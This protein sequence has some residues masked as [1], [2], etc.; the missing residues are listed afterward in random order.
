ALTNVW[1]GLLG[2]GALAGVCDTLAAPLAD[3][4]ATLGPLQ[5]LLLG[6]F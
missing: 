1:Y 4:P 3:P 6:P 2:W 5:L